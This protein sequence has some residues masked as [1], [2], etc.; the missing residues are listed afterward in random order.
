MKKKMITADVII[1]FSAPDRKA[2]LAHIM[3]DIKDAYPE[4]DVHVTMDIDSSD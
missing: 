2:V 3:K 4:Y 1:D